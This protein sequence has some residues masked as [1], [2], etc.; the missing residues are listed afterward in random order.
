MSLSAG[1]ESDFVWAV[2]LSKIWKGTFDRTWSFRTQSEGSTFALDEDEDQ[3]REN[4]SEALD[5]EGKSE[6]E[7]LW[8]GGGEGFIVL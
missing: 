2:R 3:K 8:L 4:V 7:K 5:A 1:A 6:A